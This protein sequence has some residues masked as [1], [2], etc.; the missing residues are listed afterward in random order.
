MQ[1]KLKERAN[2]STIS[3]RVLLLL[4]LAVFLLRP[5]VDK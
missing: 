4:L 1:E 2:I 5:N 3:I